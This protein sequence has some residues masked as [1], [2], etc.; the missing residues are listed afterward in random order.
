MKKTYDAVIIG[1]G[2]VGAAVFNKLVRIGKKVALIDSAS[3][4]A[5]GAS[6]ANSGL[7]H[8][9]YDPEPGT[10]KAKLNVEGAKLYPKICKRL[11]LPLKVC[12]ALVVGDDKKKVQA[13]YTRGIQNGVKELYILNRKELLKI[14]PD[15]QEHII[16]GLYAKTSAL[17]S[18]YLLTVSLC[19]EAIINGGELFLEEDLESCQKEKDIFI[20]KTKKGTFKTK[21]GTFKTKN[22]INSA[23]YGYND[24]AKILG[25]EEYPLEYRRGEYFVF[26]KDSTTKVPCTLFP[27]PT[28]KGKGVLIT[29]TVDGNYLVGPTSE[30]SDYETITTENGLKEIKEKAGLILNKVDFKNAIRVF[31]GVR[32]ICGKDFIVEKSKTNGIINLVGICSPGLSSAPAIANM[33]AKLLG[34]G[35]KELKDLKKIEPYKMLKEYPIKEQNE[36]IKKNKDYGEIVCKCEKITKGDI[37]A[38][39]KRPIKIHS[40]D[41][42]KRRTYAG[43]G[44]CQGGFCFT[45]V[46][47]IIAKTRKMKYEDV[48]K[49]NRG[50]KVA[51]GDIREV[52]DG[53]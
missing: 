45:K 46:V 30:K 11:S 37:V 4:V 14:L 40:V 12:G 53:N 41:A 36:M 21:K 7:I 42:I 34:F 2:V 50:S 13:L 51:V 1:G 18:P 8:A 39:L 9:G 19:E 23:G 47:N 17:I 49:E 44:I 10:L 22:I 3:D 31:S 38:V 32:T 15:L 28:E 48:L 20:L 24:V 16:V 25:T 43:M 27:L 35:T 6:K 26:S 52:N 33:V 5:T 29:P